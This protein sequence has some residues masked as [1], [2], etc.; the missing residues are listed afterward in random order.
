MSSSQNWILEAMERIAKDESFPHVSAL[1][2][3]MRRE[4]APSLTGLDRDQLRAFGR[5][6]E[7]RMR[8]TF[9]YWSDDADPHVEAH[10]TEYLEFVNGTW[11]KFSTLLLDVFEISLAER[12]EGDDAPATV[13][14]ELAPDGPL[15]GPQVE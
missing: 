11:G 14:R 12:E 9:P 1:L 6:L 13:Q 15:R 8:L 2:Q 7:Y 4:D 5:F 3:R 10:E